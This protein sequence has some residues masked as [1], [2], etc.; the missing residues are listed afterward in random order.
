MQNNRKSSRFRMPTRKRKGCTKYNKAKCIEQEGCHWV[1]GKGCKGDMQDMRS[2][3]SMRAEP[4]LTPDTRQPAAKSDCIDPQTGK[5][6]KK[7]PRKGPKCNEQEGC[8]WIVGK[9]CKPKE[10]IEGPATPDDTPQQP[11]AVGS[12]KVI[13]YGQS[14]DCINPK[15]G[16]GYLKGRKPKCE[17]QPGCHWEP[18]SY[19]S[20]WKKRRKGRCLRREVIKPTI[21]SAEKM[22]SILGETIESLQDKFVSESLIGNSQQVAD[23][24]FK[25]A[26]VLSAL[27]NP[28]AMQRIVN[29][30]F[31]DALTPLLEEWWELTEKNEPERDAVNPTRS[32]APNLLLFKFWATALFLEEDYLSAF[33]T[34][35]SLLTAA[36]STRTE[37]FRSI[38]RIMSM[39]ELEI[40]DMLDA[41]KFVE[42]QLQKITDTIIREFDKIIKEAASSIDKEIKDEMGVSKQLVFFASD[43]E[44]EDDEDDD[45]TPIREEEEEESEEFQRAI[46]LSRQPEVV[47]VVGGEKNEK[48]ELTL[49][50]YLNLL[51]NALSPE[52]KSVIPFAPII[53]ILTDHVQPKISLPD[54]NEVEKAVVTTLAR[55]PTAM[56]SV[57]NRYFARRDLGFGPI[58]DRFG[59]PENTGVLFN[60][61][62]SDSFEN[63]SNKI[64]SELGTIDETTPVFLFGD[65]FNQQKPTASKISEQLL[66]IDTAL[67]SKSMEHDALLDSNQQKDALRAAA[68]I[69][70]YFSNNSDKLL[71]EFSPEMVVYGQVLQ[72]L[73]GF[74]ANKLRELVSSSGFGGYKD[75]VPEV[76]K[77]ARAAKMEH[78]NVQVDP[79]TWS[80]ADPDHARSTAMATFLYTFLSSKDP[81]YSPTEDWVK[82]K[83][84]FT[85]ILLTFWTRTLY[86]N[87]LLLAVQGADINDERILEAMDEHTDGYADG[88]V[89]LDNDSNERQKLMEFSPEMTIMSWSQIDN[90][91]LDSSSLKIVLKEFLI[92]GV[93]N[94]LEIGEIGNLLDRSGTTSIPF[95]LNEIPSKRETNDEKQRTSE[96]WW[97]TLTNRSSKSPLYKVPY[98]KSN[99]L[100]RVFQ[101]ALGVGPWELSEERAGELESDKEWYDK[102]YQVPEKEQNIKNCETLDGAGSETKLKKHLAANPRNLVLALRV[103]DEYRYRC[104]SIDE[105]RSLFWQGTLAQVEGTNKYGGYLEKE[106]WDQKAI[107]ELHDGIPWQ[108]DD[109]GD[110]FRTPEGDPVLNDDFVAA[111]ERIARM[112]QGRPYLWFWK[113]LSCSALTYKQFTGD[114][115]EKYRKEVSEYLMTEGIT[116][117]D[118]QRKKILR[119][120]RDSLLESQA[121]AETGGT[122]SDDG[123]PPLFTWDPRTSPDYENQDFARD[124]AVA[125]RQL[126]MFCEGA[127]MGGDYERLVDETWLK[128]EKDYLE[129]HDVRLT[130]VNPIDNLKVY[131]QDKAALETAALE[132]AALEARRKAHEASKKYDEAIEKADEAGEKAREAADKATEAADK[133][134]EA[135]DKADEASK[136]AYEVSKKASEAVSLGVPTEKAY[137]AY[138][139]AIAAADKARE[140]ADKAHEAR[141]EAR[142]ARDEAREARDKARDKARNEAREAR[143]KAREARD[144]VALQLHLSN[145][146][147]EAR[148]RDSTESYPMVMLLGPG[149]GSFQTLI[150]RWMF[151]TEVKDN[152][153]WWQQLVPPDGPVSEFFSDSS[154]IFLLEEIDVIQRFTSNG[155][156]PKMLRLGSPIGPDLFA[157]DPDMKYSLANSGQGDDPNYKPEMYLSYD[158][159]LLSRAF[160]E[161]KRRPGHGGAFN[162]AAVY[163]ALEGDG[164]LH[165]DDEYDLERWTRTNNAFS[166][167][168]ADHCSQKN[169]VGVYLLK[170][171]EAFDLEG[172]E[173]DE[174]EITDDEADDEAEEMTFEAMRSILDEVIEENDVEEVD[175]D[176]QRQAKADAAAIAIAEFEA[177]IRVRDSEGRLPGNWFLVKS[178]LQMYGPAMAKYGRQWVMKFMQIR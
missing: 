36:W 41:L 106:G 124:P 66:N 160:E 118:S 8:H 59:G 49:I 104:T 144:E 164:S 42:S 78:R 135:G 52:V 53:G 161:G 69:K 62:M 48:D 176:E 122:L 37:A 27:T 70:E 38:V 155:I 119:D 148:N 75:Y 170:E 154:R 11:I 120:L 95:A 102:K 101:G 51:R 113:C 79:R 105:I 55:I 98:L 3:R 117:T 114:K 93:L 89:L 85:R 17:D 130:H 136:K 140:A 145:I 173:E 167:V 121:F 58:P 143:D 73:K 153:N 29:K 22:Q 63:E 125:A 54:V 10:K 76:W 171:M 116:D 103:N 57:N 56:M 28:M 100:T 156:V 137:E 131:D 31:S 86:S 81:V 175:E 172:G 90:A 47:E 128:T 152:T 141:D 142:E 174:V 64:L 146:S 157:K 35:N 162:S 97:Q 32:D 107:D 40:P 112:E 9:G 60:E 50:E 168:S 2:Q 15:T 45:F 23:N 110:I 166:L 12:V 92:R 158:N 165:I 18:G 24:F 132:A 14:S 88:V 6:Y 87:Q 99:P 115:L 65:A 178:R 7:N 13:E 82:N 169:Y 123:V 134:D 44:T 34:E 1:I 94:W 4:V 96:K 77:Q 72:D 133:A 80:S 71:M 16:K 159:H 43:D 127:L 150:P 26:T 139:K 83:Q 108:R 5:E 74:F 138:N 84:E 111:R 61:M 20:R 109:D 33:I 25:L 126:Q 91:P 163:G 149:G 30:V 68:E 21:L 67:D 46:E 177:R 129:K 39:R 19:V 147:R 151:W